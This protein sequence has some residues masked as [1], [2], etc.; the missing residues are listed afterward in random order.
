LC[1]VNGSGVE[2]YQ[3]SLITVRLRNEAPSG[4]PKYV[5]VR[6][7]DPSAPSGSTRTLVHVYGP[8]DAV[9]EDVLLGDEFAALVAGY[10]AGRPVWGSE[11]EILQGQSVE[12]TY[13]FAEPRGLAGDPAV[14]LPGT[15]VPAGVQLITVA[16][17]QRCA[18]DVLADPRLA[19]ALGTRT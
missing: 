9:I 17:T 12:L 14:V 1:L 13:V 11:A 7:D 2:D 8:T 4:L 19:R 10:E 6:L 18:A 16:G 15:A 3:L 5:D